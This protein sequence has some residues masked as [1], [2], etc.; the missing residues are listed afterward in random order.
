MTLPP[1]LAG[2]VQF[3]QICRSVVVALAGRD[4]TCFMVGSRLSGQ[5]D[6]VEIDRGHDFV[7]NR[8][9]ISSYRSS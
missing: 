3:G 2:A 8:C 7:C 4:V 5:A 9:E 6:A 1:D